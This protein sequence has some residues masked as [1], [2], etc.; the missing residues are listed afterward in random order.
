M[1]SSSAPTV[2]DVTEA[3]AE[4]WAA[5]FTGYRTFYKLPLDDAAVATTW[6]WVLS[7]EH[8]LR[9]IVAV[10]A[11]GTLL[12]LANLRIFA[13]PSV[14]GMGLYL[15]DLFTSPE[16]R[17]QGAASALL[18]RAAEIAGENGAQVVRWITATDNTAARRVYDA[19]ATATP[20]VTYDM[21]PRTV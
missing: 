20:W 17:G 19:H 11:D 14:G 9:S 18:T 16:A 21:P 2:R 13:R 6:R 15:D 7:R 12:A 10:A 1:N 5:L 4:A 8:G 3:D